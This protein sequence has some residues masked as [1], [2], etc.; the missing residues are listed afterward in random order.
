MGGLR[1]VLTLAG[2]A[3]LLASYD[4]SILVLGLPGIAAE[5]HAQV[6]ALS[7]LGSVLALGALGALPLAA[8]AD[9]AGRRRVLAGAVLAFSLIDLA[10]A[11]APSLAWL[12][13]TRLVGVCF[14]TV[15]AGVATA[16]VVEVT[17]A[18]HRALAVS[19]L[20]LAAGRLGGH[21]AGPPAAVRI[22]VWL[23]PDR[24]AL[25]LGVDL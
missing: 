12:A 25:D 19:G 24:P 18:R 21:E 3:V 15:T 7:D 13:G 9:V 20:T 17:P 4:S 8:L 14:E 1:R 2:L 5:F 22:G 23:A 6:P 10:S 16:L 11:L